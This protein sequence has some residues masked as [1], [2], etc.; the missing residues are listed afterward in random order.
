[1]WHTWTLDPLASWAMLLATWNYTKLIPYFEKDTKE[2]EFK[3]SLDGTSPSYDTDTEISYISDDEK[4][5][6]KESI[7][8]DYIKD[9]LK[10]DFTWEIEQIPPKYSA[11]K[12]WWQ[13]ALLKLKSGEEFEMKPRKV[14]VLSI[15]LLNYT[16]PDLTLKAEVS[17]GTYIRSIAFDLWKILWTWAYIKELRRTKIGKL[18]LFLSQ[19]LDSFSSDNK[20]DEKN[21]FGEGLFVELDSDVLEKINNGMKVKQ[22]FDFPV[23]KDL[24]VHDKEGNIT[25]VVM[26]DGIH[27][28]AR[29][30]I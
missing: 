14:T 21:L 3:L 4:K 13:K 1:M 25:N 19:G 22:V 8:L 24:F 10:R 12:M 28:F 17:A 7:K 29:R 23:W 16:Y 30:K 15:E 5:H 9:I 2:Y 11:I 26:Y 18:D 6:F 20:L 27:L